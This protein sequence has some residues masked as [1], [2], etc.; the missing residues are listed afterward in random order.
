MNNVST[1]DFNSNNRRVIDLD[2]SPWFVAADACAKWLLPTEIK[3]FPLAW[4]QSTFRLPGGHGGT[5]HSIA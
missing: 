1:F 2:G 5:R 4:S 3:D